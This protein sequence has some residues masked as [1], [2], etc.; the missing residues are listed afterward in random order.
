MFHLKKKLI[1]LYFLRQGFLTFSDSSCF[2]N[3]SAL[4]SKIQVVYSR[5]W[6]LIYWRLKYI[7]YVLFVNWTSVLK[8]PSLWLQGADLFSSKALNHVSIKI[9]LCFKDQS[10]I[11]FSKFLG[12]KF[13]WKCHQCLAMDVM[14]ECVVRNCYIL[15]EA[16]YTHTLALLLGSVFIES[17]DSIKNAA[18]K[19]SISYLW[20]TC[21]TPVIRV[22][23]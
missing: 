8:S 7:I 9:H 18:N 3:L 19:S 6:L 22:H 12:L 21:L 15:I 2:G 20:R 17:N 23:T 1:L 13:V 4:F 11:G 10:I 16:I 14:A 5:T